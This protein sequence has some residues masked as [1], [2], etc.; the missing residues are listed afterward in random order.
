MKMQERKVRE[1]RTPR[2]FYFGSL[3]PE[4]HPVCQGNLSLILHYFKSFTKYPPLHFQNMQKHHKRLLN[5]TRITPAQQEP[6]CRPGK[7]LGTH[8]KLEKDQTSV[9]A[10]PSLPQT[11]FSKLQTKPKA[12]RIDPRSIF[13]NSN[14]YDHEGESI[15]TFPEQIHALK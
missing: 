4:L 13:N 9:V 2:D 12:P 1:E 15:H 6:F 7:P 3:K 14:T 10:Q 8:T 5:H 11:T